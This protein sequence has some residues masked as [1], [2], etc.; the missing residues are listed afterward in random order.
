MTKC[1]ILEAERKKNYVVKNR[2][3]K[4]TQNSTQKQQMYGLGKDYR[5]S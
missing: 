3:E 1:V 4:E 2:N 5:V